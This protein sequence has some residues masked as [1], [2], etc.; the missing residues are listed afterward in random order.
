MYFNLHRVDTNI[1]FKP[2]ELVG[3]IQDCK[4]RKY[5]VYVCS[6]RY[7]C[8]GLGDRQKGIVSTYLLS[9]LT[10][11]TFIMIHTKPCELTNFLHFKLD[12][13]T[14]CYSHIINLP[15]NASQTF[16]YMSG[17]YKMNETIAKSNLT[18]LFKKQVVYIRTNGL[19]IQDMLGHPKAKTALS[20][21]MDKRDYDV[22]VLTLQRL[23]EPTKSLTYELDNFLAHHT[24]ERTLVCAHIR[25][26]KNPTLPLDNNLERGKPEVATI[27][28][29]LKQFDNPTKYA[30][31]I[32]SDSVDVKAQAKEAMSNVFTL[33]EP[34]IHVDRYLQ[35]QTTMAC[36][37]LKT[38]IFE[39]LALSRC[40][41]LLHTRGN[42]GR[43]AS[44]MSRDLKQCHIF[45][46]KTNTILNF[47]GRCK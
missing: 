39:Q 14:R 32:A 1:K 16:D 5:M 21:A 27:F 36:D 11:R 12:H 8:G 24:H 7:L 28:K 2:S 4:H 38:I 9:Q 35:N 3:K 29:F 33:N 13:W 42:I 26:G 44:I 37:G 20:W 17:H 34:I 31:Y 22:N 10:N 15:T 43:T 23:F 25:M 46:A 45:D 6:Q 19:S 18:E 47:T 30:V 40:Q 41:I